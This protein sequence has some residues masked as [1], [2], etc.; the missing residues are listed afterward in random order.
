M[1]EFTISTGHDWLRLTFDQVYRFPEH[2]SH[3]G[4]YDVGGMLTL[5]CGAYH[6]HGSLSLSTG[7]VWEFYSALRE[8]YEALAGEAQFHSSEGNLKFTLRFTTRGHWI[9]EGKYQERD[10][11]PTKL[12]FEMEGEQSYL[13]ETIRQLANIVATYGDNRGI[14]R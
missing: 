5:R 4:G 9:L 2:T 7:E 14:P 6:V 11:I 8:A 1:D 3:F 13:N 12:T 10:D